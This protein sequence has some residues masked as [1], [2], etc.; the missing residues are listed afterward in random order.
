MHIQLLENENKKEDE[1]ANAYVGGPAKNL[2]KKIIEKIY[3]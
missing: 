3:F 2:K 1:E